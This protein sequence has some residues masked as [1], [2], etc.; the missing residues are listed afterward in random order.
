MSEA[1]RSVTLG[2]IALGSEPLSYQW[3][4]QTNAVVGATNATLVMTNLVSNQT[5]LYRV[6]VTNPYGSAESAP[7]QLT[8]FEPGPLEFRIENLGTDA[9]LVEHYFLTGDDRGGI[10]LTDSQVFV[11]GDNSTARFRSEDLTAGTPLNV[12][13]DGLVS[14]LRTRNTYVF[15]VGDTTSLTLLDPETGDMTG[16]VIQLSQNIP[17]W[18]GG[19]A[20]FSGFGR[21]M[22]RPGQNGH[23]YEIKLPDGEVIDHGPQPL[24]DLSGSESWASWGVLEYFDGQLQLVY[25]AAYSSTIVRRALGSSVPT[26]VRVFDNLGDMGSFTV[27]PYRGRWYFHHSGYSQFGGFGETLGFASA[28][29]VFSSGSNQP[30]AFFGQPASQT[31]LSGQPAQF[32]ASAFGANP[33][34]YQWSRNDQPIAKATNRVLIMTSVTPADTGVYRVAVTN[35]FGGTNSQPAALSVVDS[36]TLFFQVHSLGTNAVTTDHAHLTGDDRGGIA[37]S[38]NHVFVTGD[39]ASARFNKTDLGAGTSLGSVYDG[40]ISDL[41][42][43]TAYVLGV[44]NVVWN[45]YIEPA[46]SLIRLDAATGLPT[47]DIIVLSRPIPL[48]WG[49][50]LFAGFGRFVALSSADGRGYDVLLPSGT[51]IDL[52]PQS[53]GDAHQSESW[54]AWGVVEYYDNTLH[55][56][57]RHANLPWIVRRHLGA[58]NSTAFAE[59]NNLA[60]LASFVVDPYLGRWYFAHQFNSQFASGTQIVGFAPAATSYYAATNQP[61]N[62]LSQ[63]APQTADLGGAVSFTVNAIGTAPLG[64][65][66]W[67]NSTP[68]A[69]ATNATLALANLSSVQAGLYR[70]VVSN[71]F[72]MVTSTPAALQ[73]SG[74]LS[75]RFRIVSLGTNAVTTDHEAIT[76][77]DRGGIA[78]S[79]AS[80][81]I[82]GDT[83]SGR[84]ARD[85]LSGGTAINRVY[86]GL[87]SDL[88]A[89]KAY[90]LGLNGAPLISGQAS[91]NTLIALDSQTGQLTAEVIPLSQSIPLGTPSGVFSGYGRIVVRSGGN[92]RAYDIV[93][94]SGQVTDLGA[95]PLED[96]NIFSETWAYWGVAE[97]FNDSLHLVYRSF[98]NQI[99][100]RTVGTS[101]STAIA[102]FN[103]LS[104]LTSFSVDVE[105]GRWYFHHEGV[106]ELGS[107]QEVLGYANA[108][109]EI[110]PDSNQAPIITSQ[111]ISVRTFAGR[112]AHMW[113]NL[114][115]GDPTHYQWFRNG[116]PIPS[117]V[118]P[119]LGITNATPGDTGFY[120]IEVTNQQGRAVSERAFVLVEE[121]VVPT[122]INATYLHS[123]TESAWGDY[124]NANALNRVFGSNEWAS[125]TFE[126]ADIPAVF[127]ATNQ[128]IMIEGGANTADAFEAFLL[129]HREPIELWVTNGGSLFLSSAP[130]TGNG[131]ALGFAGLQMT[132]PNYQ[133]SVSL[134][135]SPTPL[136]TGPFLPT[137][138]IWSGTY[139]ANATVGGPQLT[140][141]LR[142]DNTGGIVV[143]EKQFG[144]GRVLVST[145]TPPSFHQPGSEAQNLRANL[146]AYATSAPAVSESPFLHYLH[147]A[148]PGGNEL[149]LAAAQ[150]PGSPVWLQYSTNLFAWKSI[151]TNVVPPSGMLMVPVPIDPNT[152]AGFYRIL[153]P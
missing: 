18:G 4:F 8:V 141:L 88:R 72:G 133:S 114:V 103:N 47:S 101:S 23:A 148:A 93:L 96:A 7:A 139:A 57:Y 24:E 112:T 66:W 111:P 67:H 76:G 131:M 102:S 48:A 86:D 108:A 130:T 149:L 99:V 52:G 137:G 54:A 2:T 49:S 138:T 16:E 98:A 151:S 55:F 144:G 17:T 11:T 21:A 78:L 10:A 85:N 59:F 38:E 120:W 42:S 19:S 109:F 15:N 79:S 82:T 33:L 45:S 90:T 43:R 34:Y 56:L 132:F 119:S 84:F 5:G 28:E 1:G 39:A 143:G 60:D 27:D 31:V 69:S 83:S 75:S 140:A 126:T 121:A 146:L 118:G 58:S 44:S 20:V 97:F 117:L 116:T 122:S 68:L 22:I 50:Q 40:L 100:R 77:D 3:Y 61:P 123:A 70:V 153:N 35:A 46:T 80:V 51:V 104:D 12:I 81:F 110:Q 65:R 115:G 95:T 136:A 6:R 30:P 94:P 124:D 63:P 147:V 29:V 13:H 107:G 135:S 134:A 105:L 113:I 91:A 128:L 71:P 89:R 36:A 73:L 25:R 62:I 125:F 152:D 41:R 14:D 92:G 37:I 32:S 74:P 87:C 127:S 129:Q 64:Y 26:A 9:T 150:Q 142:G 106:S 145:L 53:R